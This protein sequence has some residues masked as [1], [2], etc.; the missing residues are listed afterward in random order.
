MKKAL[1]I[2]L[3]SIGLLVMA[4]AV[5]ALLIPWMNTW[6]ASSVE[7]NAAYPGDELVPEPATF[8]NRAVSINASA[9]QIFPWL[10]QLGALKGGMYS[11]EWFETNILRCELINA[12]RI[13]PEWQDLKVGDLVRMCPGDFGP[14]PYTVAM[15]EPNRALILGHQEDGRWVE[16]WQLVL[17]PQLDGTTRLIQRTRSEL[18]GGFW[19]VIHPGVFLMERGMMLGIKER[20]EGLATTGLPTTASTPEADMSLYTSPEP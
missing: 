3:V 13:H 1:K 7:I 6:G 12:D 8:V 14:V 2:L 19:T 16:L 18:S 9:E 10:V 5:V 4:V 20:A 17:E 11:Y 15:I